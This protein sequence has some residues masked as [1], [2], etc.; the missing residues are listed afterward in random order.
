[1]KP[2][3]LLAVFLV[4]MGLI[5]AAVPQNKSKQNRLN[6]SDLITEISSGSQY[7]EPENVADMLV[8]KDP[9]LRLIDVRS[10]EAFEKYSLPGAVNVPLPELLSDQNEGFLADET[11]TNVFYS[12]GS[13]DANEAWMLAKQMGYENC[14]VLRGGLNYWFEAIL[15]PQKPSSV[16]ADDE[17]AKY[18][19]RV[20]T[21]QALGGGSVVQAASEPQKQ[22]SSASP[23]PVAKKKKASGGC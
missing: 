13:S 6:A 17:L 19:F 1:M 2:R 4:P 20:G 10:Q 15:N 5:I 3:T 22:V 7:M 9:S 12:N 16:S 11:K 18:D 21:S 14:Y 8:S 23:K